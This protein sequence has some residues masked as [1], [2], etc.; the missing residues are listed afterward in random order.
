MPTLGKSVWGSKGLG[1]DVVQDIQASLEGL[2]E[3]QSEIVDS[4]YDSRSYS[5]K[6]IVEGT[7]VVFT[8]NSSL[9]GYGTIRWTKRGSG[10]QVITD[11]VLA[12]AYRYDISEAKVLKALK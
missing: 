6:L 8:Y 5:K 2:S 7:P 12:S 3:S 1:F 9:P 11:A 4:D 10:N